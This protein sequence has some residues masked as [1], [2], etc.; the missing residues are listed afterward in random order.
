MSSF[1]GVFSEVYI[2][3]L[4]GYAC[5]M[6]LMEFYTIRDKIC[7]ETYPGKNIPNSPYKIEDHEGIK[8]L[9]IGHLTI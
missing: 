6:I 3:V 8:E 2:T 5:E 1:T 9:I 4:S 7:P